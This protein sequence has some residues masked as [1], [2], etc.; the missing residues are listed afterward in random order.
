MAL[1]TFVNM[2]ASLV[3]TF[4]FTFLV[5]FLQGYSF[6]VFG[7]FMGLALFVICLKVNKRTEPLTPITIIYWFIYK[8][9]IFSVC[10]KMAETKGKTVEEIL[11][12]FQPA[13]DTE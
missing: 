5:M 9:P 10:F 12:S 4:T 2:T 11:Q 3:I 6:F 8:K 13:D 1:T 7:F